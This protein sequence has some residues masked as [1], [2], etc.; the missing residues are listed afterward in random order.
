MGKQRKLLPIIKERNPLYLGH[1][2]SGRKYE[3]I[4]AKEKSL[5][6]DVYDTKILG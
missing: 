4:R 2:M 5:A 3:M 1:I 6:R